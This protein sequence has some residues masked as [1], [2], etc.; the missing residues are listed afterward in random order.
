MA[1]KGQCSYSEISC[2]GTLVP[3]KMQIGKL[4]AK[5]IT[6]ARLETCSLHHRSPSLVLKLLL[7]HYCLSPNYRRISQERKWFAFIVVNNSGAMSVK[8]SPLWQLGKKRSR[9]T[10]LF[11]SDKVANRKAV[12]WRRRVFIANKEIVTTEVSA[13]RRFQLRS[14]QKWHILLL[15]PYPLLLLQS[16]P[17][18]PLT[19]K[20]WCKLS[21]LK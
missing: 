14:P 7:V 3:G 11:V 21:P 17:C 2:I 19:S 15:N 9:D 5:L 16:I 20:Y 18:C 6:K 10:V 4:L 12:Q 8:R 1:M 13:L